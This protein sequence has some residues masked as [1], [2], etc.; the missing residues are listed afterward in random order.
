VNDFDGMQRLTRLVDDLVERLAVPRYPTDWTW[1][2]RRQALVLAR[3]DQAVDLIAA[4]MHHG[5]PD[6]RAGMAEL[7]ARMERGR[8]RPHLVAALSD[9]HDSVRYAAVRVLAADRDEVAWLAALDIFRHGRFYMFEG[10][11]EV[12]V[13]WRP[14]AMVPLLVARLP[15]LEW[16]ISSRIFAALSRCG[17]AGLDAL[18]RLLEHPDGSTRRDATWSLGWSFD[19]ARIPALMRRLADPAREVRDAAV[20]SLGRMGAREAEPA[21]AAF[22][23]RPGAAHPG[24]LLEALSR[25]GSPRVRAPLLDAARN[26]ADQGYANAVKGLAGFPWAPDIEA[27]LLDGVRAAKDIEACAEA[28]HLLLAHCDD[29]LMPEVIRLAKR[30]SRMLTRSG[31]KAMWRRIRAREELGRAASGRSPSSGEAAARRPS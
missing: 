11:L 5:N 24:Y 26:P 14:E 12:L 9:P 1:L 22:L 3:E 25:V 6:V 28:L 15:E 20:A 18:E 23:D 13:A 29:A 7:L 17:G 16:N 27:A 2:R 31:R 19:R 10:V 21:L 8:A 4:A 30:Q